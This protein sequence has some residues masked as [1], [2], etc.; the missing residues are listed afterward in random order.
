MI[1][2]CT[3]GIYVYGAAPT[4]FHN[5]ILDPYGNGIFGETIGYAPLIK[6]NTIKKLTNNLYNYEGIYFTNNSAA[7]HITGNDIQ[8]FDYGFYFGGGGETYFWDDHYITS[9]PN[10]RFANNVTGFCAAWGSFIMAGYTGNPPWCAYNSISNNSSYDAKAYQNGR[11]TAQFNWWGNDGAQLSTS[12]GGTIDAS[13]P[14]NY[15]PWLPPKGNMIVKQE[16]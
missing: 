13:N 15:D 4:I 8:G 14:L 6:G 2:H 5:N 12:S 7:S 3:H 9:F 11:I 1:D 10:N 16:P